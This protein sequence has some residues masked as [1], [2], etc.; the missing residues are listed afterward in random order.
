MVLGA[1]GRRARR[2]T[3]RRGGASRRARPAGSGR[4]RR[5]GRARGGTRTASRPRRGA[6]LAADELLALEAV[7]ASSRRPAR[8][9]D[10]APGQKT[11]PTTDAS[12]SSAFSSGA[13]A[14]RRA[15]ID[16]LHRLGQRQ[17][18]APSPRSRRAC[19]R[20]PPRRAGCRPRAQQRLLRRRRRARRGRGAR[21]S[22]RRSRRRRAAPSESVS[23]LRLP[24]PQPG[25]RS[26][27]SGRA[28]PTT[29]SGTSRRPV[30]ELVDEVEQ[31]VVGPVQILEDEH[32]RAAARRAPREAAARPRTPRRASAAPPPRRGRPAGASCARRPGALAS[33]ARAST[34]DAELLLAPSAA[35]SVSRIPACAL[36]ISPSAQKLTP[37]PYGRQ[38]PWRQLIS[39]GSRF[40]DLEQ[41]GDEPALADA[42]HADERHEL[43]RSLAPA[44]SSASSEQRRARARGRRAARAA[45]ARR[46][47]RSATR[48][49]SASQA[50]T[51]SAF[52]FAST[53]ARSRYSIAS[54]VA[55]YVASPTRSRPTGAADCRRAAVLTTSP[56][57][58]ASP[59]AG[60]RTERDER[61]A[62]VDGD[63]DLRARPSLESL[64]SRIASAARTAR[65][66]SSSCATGAPKTRH[67]GVADEL[68][69]RAA[70]PLEIARGRA[71]GTAESSA[72]TSSGSSARRAPWSRRGRRR[73]TRDDLAVP[74]ARARRRRAGART[75]RRSGSFRGSPG[76]SAARDHA[77]HTRPESSVH[78]EPC[79][80]ASADHGATCLFRRTRAWL[81]RKFDAR[82]RAGEGWPRYAARGHFSSS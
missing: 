72:R 3:P 61:L 67:H 76:R 31:A 20:T 15:A 39:S 23:A 50:G 14:S 59:C 58:I 16:A 28:V 6:A 55:R 11:L 42:R 22:S 79:L 75:S 10:A 17:L 81:E 49:A 71:R 52:P 2:A 29:S 36:T 69:D 1:V 12:C 26:S 32:E 68:L 13:S 63:P 30:G 70:V 73:A 47:R 53:G 25:R 37:S 19:A 48:A 41:L 54:R 60:A 78:H 82:R 21:A 18:V 40:D 66:A 65:S 7:Q 33:S 56:A 62:R 8:R 34:I 44:R 38:R 51:G 27:S 4:R 43:A 80:H 9:C 46:R 35:S 24:P 77:V 57:T 45:P 5:R 64:Q 74:R